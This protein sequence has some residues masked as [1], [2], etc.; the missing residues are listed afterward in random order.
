MAL[1]GEN[2]Q[3]LLCFGAPASKILNLFAVGLFVCYLGDDD[4]RNLI[5]SCPG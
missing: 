1:I 5:R 4:S 2:A 3:L